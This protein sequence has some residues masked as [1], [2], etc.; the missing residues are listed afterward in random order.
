MKITSITLH[1]SAFPLQKPFVT[2]LR[3]VDSV[4]VFHLIIETDEG[5]CGT[6]AASPTEAITGETVKTIKEGTAIFDNLL[7]GR[8]LDDLNG[9]LEEVQTAVPGY[10]AAKAAVDMALYDLFSGKSNLPLCRFLGG[11]PSGIETDLT[12]SLREK[13]QMVA[14][15]LEAEKR[16]FHTLKIKLGDEWS[17]DVDRFQGIAEAV[18]C[19]LRID[20]NQGWSVEDTLRFMDRLERTGREIDLLEQPV[21][22]D[23]LKGMAAIRE[24]I[25]CPLAA[26][27][28]VFSPRDALR[29]ID[30]GAADIINIKLLKSGGIRQAGKIAALIDT[31]GLTGMIGC[32]MESPVGIAAALHFAAANPVIR[33]YDLDVPL[34]LKEIPEGYGLSCSGIRIAPRDY[35]GLGE[36]ALA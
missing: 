8:E 28:S 6:G 18:S 3:R 33:Y 2:A 21:K 30:A 24:R 23:D 27:E 17:R 7:K 31:A 11:S 13:N 5:I 35:P 19:R 4:Q 25:S 16:G 32:M 10:I 26:D 22:A 12:I 9:L 29:V 36:C 34:L 15:A 14:D 1:E 20:A